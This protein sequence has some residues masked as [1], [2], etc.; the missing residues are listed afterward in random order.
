MHEWAIAEGIVSTIVSLSLKE[1]AK[2]VTKVVISIG[3]LSQLN[4]EILRDAIKELSEGTIMEDAEIVFQVE[5]AIFKCLN[6]GFS[7]SFGSVKKN[8]LR[9][10]CGEDVEECDNPVHYVPDLVNVFLRCPKCGSPDFEISSGR[11]VKIVS[12]EVVK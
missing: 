1:G 8:L 7:W 6:C 10:F 2:K 9:M 4:L 12:V 3:E 11:G 5:E